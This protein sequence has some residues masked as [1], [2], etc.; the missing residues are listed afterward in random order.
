[1][2]RIRLSDHFTTRRLLRYTLP[3]VLMMIFTSIYGVI[4]GL[5]V[6][7]FA[8]KTAFAAV[9]FA[10]PLIMMLAAAG[11]MFGAGGSALVAKT[12]GEGKRE[13]AQQTFSLIVY[14]SILVGFGV[15]ALGFAVVRSVLVWM[16][17]E[18]EMLE[19]AVRYAHICFVA[20]PAYVLQLEFS[21]LFVTAEKP[22]L[23]LRVTVAAGLTNIV[24]DFLLVAVFDWGVTGAAVATGL[25][26]C[27]GG[28]FPVVYFARP[29]SSVLRLTRTRFDG[30]AL[31]RTVSNGVSELLSNISMSLVG[32]LYNIQLIRYAGENGVAAYGVMMYVNFLFLATYIGFSNGS[33]PIVSYHYGAEDR[34]ELRNLLRKSLSII[35]TLAVCMLAAG[36]LLAIPLAR[37]F[38]GYDAELMALTVHGF[39]IFSFSFLFA[40]MAIYTSSF[41]TA[42]NNGL[43]SAVIA[44]LRTLVFEVLC[45]LFLPLVL[46]TDGI[47]A[48][49]VVAELSAATV[50]TVLLL[51]NR[52]K[53][54]YF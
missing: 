37:L 30:Y 33:A 53:Y 8:G 44:F 16:G 3:T 42:L 4:D 50:G 26:E 1:M 29:N 2:S 52:K 28:L 24:L 12:L 5:F 41:F 23:G 47:W 27:V 14:T 51:L 54:G 48:S 25:S 39:R 49:I 17:G 6:S 31:W 18:G 19:L 7:N 38:V 15:M 11:F 13:K 34:E 35:W 9:N 21:T 40:G 20:L 10:M 32:M 22:G 46:G 43:M 36:E 45:V